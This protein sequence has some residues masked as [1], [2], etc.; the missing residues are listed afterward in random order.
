MSPQAD[1]ARIALIHAAIDA[2]NAHLAIN[3]A[4]PLLGEMPYDSGGEDFPDEAN[5]T[6]ADVMMWSS[7]LSAS[8]NKLPSSERAQLLGGV[9]EAYRRVGDDSAALARYRQAWHLED[10]PAQRKEL[11]AQIRSLRHAIARNAANEQCAPAIH[12]AT[13]QN[14]PVRPRLLVSTER[15]EP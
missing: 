7:R 13:D 4:A 2:K 8:W 12:E 15:K 11:T 9:A 3:A 6:N 1:S 5:E 10:D 14:H